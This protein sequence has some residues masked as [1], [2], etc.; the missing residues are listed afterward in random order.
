MHHYINSFIIVNYNQIPLILID[1]EFALCDDIP[2]LD[3]KRGDLLHQIEQLSKILKREDHN[4][5]VLSKI[6]IDDSKSILYIAN[7]F[8][9]EDIEVVGVYADRVSQKDYDILSNI[10]KYGVINNFSLN[11]N[12]QKTYKKSL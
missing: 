6:E 12:N 10:F 7:L 2:A 11:I 9:E 1:S 4:Q 8:E 5:I 3:D